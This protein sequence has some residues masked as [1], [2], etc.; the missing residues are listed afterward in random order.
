LLNTQQ[1]IV[2][3]TTVTAHPV[4]DPPGHSNELIHVAVGSHNRSVV[5]PPAQYE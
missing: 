5:D 2:P 3:T 4:I 1:P